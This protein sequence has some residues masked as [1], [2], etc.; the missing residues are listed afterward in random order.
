MSSTVA[1]AESAAPITLAEAPGDRAAVALRK[2]VAALIALQHDDGYWCARFEGDSILT[3]EYM[4]M[5]FILGQERDAAHQDRF[6]RITNYLRSL[7]RADGSFGQYPGSAPDISAS[8]KAYFVMKLMGDGPD[9]L[10]MKRLRS[11]I[12]AHGGAER[13]NT[14]TG[15]YLACLGQVSWDAVPTIPP[16][17]MFLPSRFPFHLTKVAAWTRT[18]IVPLSIVT[19]VRPV[20][21]LSESQGIGELFVDPRNRDRLTRAMDPQGWT[22]NNGFLTLDR[23]I[24]QLNARELIPSKQAALKQAER[25]IIERSGDLTDGLGAIFPPMV[26]QQ[27]ALHS[28]GYERDDPVMVKAERDLDALLLDVSADACDIQPCFSPVWDTGIALYALTEAGLTVEDEAVER[29]THWLRGKECTHRGDWAANARFVVEPSGWYF[30]FNNQWYPDV[31]DTA[32]VAMALHRSGGMENIAAARRGAGWLLALQN[33]DGGWA[34]FDRT[35]HRA[36]MEKTPFADHNAMQDPSCADITGRTL[37]CLHHLGYAPD[38][39]AVRRGVAFLLRSQE[40]EGCWFGRW[41]VNYL[42]GTWQALGGLVHSGLDPEHATIRQAGA[43]LRSV[44]KPDGSFGESCDTYEDASLKGQGESTASQTAWGAMSLM[45]CFGPDHP[46]AKR[47]IDWLVEAQLDD[48]S[49]ALSPDGDGPGSW[50]ES[51]YTGTGFPRVFY[52]RYHLYRLYFPLMALA[53]SVG[54]TQGFESPGIEVS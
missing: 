54:K 52:I 36:W 4:L 16:Q 34:A 33:D 15:F 10:H 32:M 37:E 48:A 40:P 14:F 49:A 13:C 2:A 47:A 1:E 21:T 39:K 27:I 18:M 46:D 35:Q 3:S 38:H 6:R 31:D 30:E 28:L 11:V 12:L 29:T 44:Q 43:W 24:K 50:T 22:W 41:G 53:R 19:A 20:R 8:V 45:F 9:A 51:Q 42:Y 17:I 7:Q 25:W 23:A 26:Y 5:K